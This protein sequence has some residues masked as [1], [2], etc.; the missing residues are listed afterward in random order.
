LGG[1][2]FVSGSKSCQWRLSFGYA[3]LMYVFCMCVRVSACLRPYV[4]EAVGIGS[5]WNCF[6]RQRLSSISSFRPHE[7][8][9]CIGISFGC[10]GPYDEQ[11]CLRRLMNPNCA[12]LV[13]SIRSAALV[14]CCRWA[15]TV[16]RRERRPVT[17][18]VSYLGS[19]LHIN[20]SWPVNRSID[21]RRLRP[22]WSMD[23]VGR[24]S[25]KEWNWEH[26]AFTSWVINWIIH[27]IIMCNILRCYHWK[28]RVYLCN[29]YLC[30]PVIF[31]YI[32]FYPWKLFI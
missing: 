28:L 9:H 8:G 12:P 1:W 10:D 25:W 30:I 5:E 16:S 11:H 19:Y 18:D 2:A 4:E 3:T 27:I 32:C 31:V 24:L 23:V 17:G 15:L 22:S 7:T 13:R 26:L 6:K 21:R 20:H 29:D 14:E